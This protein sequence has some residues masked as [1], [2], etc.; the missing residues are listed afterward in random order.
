MQHFARIR[1]PRKAF[2]FNDFRAFSPA[3][4]VRS[5]Y[6]NNTGRMYANNTGYVRQQYRL[7]IIKP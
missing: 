5:M 3:R 4:F 2:V 7:V 1:N 6:A